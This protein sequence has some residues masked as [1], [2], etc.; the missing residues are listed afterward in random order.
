MR[1][2]SFLNIC[3][4]V[5]VVTDYFSLY[6]E[7]FLN[8]KWLLLGKKSR[9]FWVIWKWTG[10]SGSKITMYL[11]RVWFT[12][13]SWWNG[14]RVS[15]IFRSRVSLHLKTISDWRSPFW[16]SPV[17]WGLS[18]EPGK[19]ASSSGEQRFTSKRVRSGQVPSHGS[20]Q[21]LLMMMMMMM[22]FQDVGSCTQF[23][24]GP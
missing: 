1:V 12:C 24:P 15:K 21:H 8:T 16:M 10:A 9:H 22:I 3:F 20:R 11:R 23:P 13:W 2:G 7:F 6:I 14:I 18:H 5:E 19:L 17:A 4:L